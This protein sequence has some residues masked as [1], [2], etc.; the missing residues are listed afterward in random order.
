MEATKDPRILTKAELN[1]YRHLSRN[2]LMDHIDALTE[3]LEFYADESNH[4]VGDESRGCEVE[5]D[6][7]RRAR[8]VLGKE[9]TR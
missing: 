6:N 2:Q 8:A 7:G 1:M 4:Y 3:V 5:V 9:A